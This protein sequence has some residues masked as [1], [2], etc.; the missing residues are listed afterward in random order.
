MKCLYVNV[1]LVYY[2]NPDLGI[3]CFLYRSLPSGA[4]EL[5]QIP[6]ETAIKLMWKIVK[7]GGWRE[8]RPNWCHYAT[9]MVS[10][11]YCKIVKD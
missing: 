4:S 2:D 6:Y 10:A 7:A 1:S 3:E 11:T 9:S 5:K 8:Y